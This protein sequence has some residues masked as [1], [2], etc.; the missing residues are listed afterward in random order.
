MPKWLVYLALIGGVLRP[1]PAAAWGFAAHRLIMREAIKLLPAE[2]KPLFEQQRDEVVLRVVDPDLWRNVNWPDDPNHFLDFGVKEY[3]AYPFNDL[4]R[5][6]GAALAKFGPTVLDRN[7]RL[8]WRLAE[9]TGYLRR[10]FEEFPRNAPYT[11]SNTILYAAV[12]AHYMQDAFQPFH[13]TDNF[14]GAATGQRG[15]HSRF[16]RDLIERYASRLVLKPASSQ[17]VSEPRD[18]AFDALLA[19]FKLVDPILKADREA[20]GGRDKYDDA[21]FESFFVNVKPILEERL[22]S[23]ISMTARLIAGAW[24]QAGR[25]AVRLNEA[26]PTQSI[27]RSR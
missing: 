8:P 1:A 23:A 13:A 9:M 3:G 24:I 11:I 14:D 16:E 22:S 25:P 2:L 27:D 21:Y 19:S 10:S 6:Y 7:G 4:P 12:S 20:A 26:R 15:I 17:P 5:D 18:A